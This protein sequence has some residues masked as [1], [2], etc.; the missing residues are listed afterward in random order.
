MRVAEEDGEVLGQLRGRRVALGGADLLVPQ[1]IQP[2][3][4]GGWAV[5]DLKRR[6]RIEEEKDRYQ[7]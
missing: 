7:C 4:N 1:T 6:I 5:A 3:Q 2:K